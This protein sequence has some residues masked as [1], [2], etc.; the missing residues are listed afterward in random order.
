ME[1]PAVA[2]KI[3]LPAGAGALA[4]VL[5]TDKESDF[6]GS[7]VLLSEVVYLF[8]GEPPRIPSSY[9]LGNFP[10]GWV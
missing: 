9:T 6:I 2:G 10:T 4:F 5:V 3:F 7:V 1:A 8:Y